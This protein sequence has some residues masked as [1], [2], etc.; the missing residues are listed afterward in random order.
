MITL[1]E[2]PPDNHVLAKKSLEDVK[3]TS[4]ISES[5][6][7]PILSTMATTTITAAATSTANTTQVRIQLST[8]DE[9]IE[10][11]EKPGPILVSTSKEITSSYTKHNI[12]LLTHSKQLLDLRRYALSTLCNTLLESPTPVPFEFLINGQFLR[13]SIDD[14]LTT[15]GISAETTLNVEYIRAQLPPQHLASFEHDDWVSSVDVLS[16]TS[17]ASIWT[18]S[19]VA[20][21]QERILS[22]SYDG[23]LRVW[24]MSGNIVATSPAARDHTGT[25]QKILSTAW[26]SPTSLVS[27]GWNR[28][29]TVWSYNEN[30]NDSNDLTASNRGTISPTLDLYGHRGPVNAL[31]VHTPTSHILSASTDHTA[32]LW[33]TSPSSQTT[34]APSNLLPTS[35]INSNKRRKLSSSASST[36]TAG[37]SS[38]L[39]GHTGPVRST[40]FHPADATVAYTASS[41][42]TFRTWDLVTSACVSSR[43]VAAHT[44][45]SALCGLK[46]LGLVAIGTTSARTVLLVDPRES[47][48]DA[49][50]GKSVVMSLKGHRNDVVTLAADPRSIWGLGSGSHDG[51][52]RVWDVRNA[53]GGEALGGGGED[54]KVGS[55]TFRVPRRGNERCDVVPGGEGVKVFGMCWDEEVGIV[56]GGEDRMVQI[57]KS[58][59]GGGR[60][61]E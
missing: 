15:N 46:E 9:S 61:C 55:A 57:D 7:Q 2:S 45:L 4:N 13:T 40:I 24:D 47:S 51:T 50:A 48:S 14:F 1:T 35:F 44:P 26:L 58:G 38:R 17:P 25:A 31:A 23:L 5:S 22:A 60:S 41:D 37:P 20:S 52:V 28:S 49:G 8:R 32:F 19:N 53:K 3:Q 33:S 59:G 10:F 18:K 12:P 30:N 21:G 16:R 29:I 6:L 36:P 42:R 11:P 54:S 43:V 56:S 27:A 39:I 34:P